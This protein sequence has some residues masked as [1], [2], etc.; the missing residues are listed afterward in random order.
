MNPTKIILFIAGFFVFI[1]ASKYFMVVKSLL[2]LRFKKT[3]GEIKQLNELPQYLK[4]LLPSYDIKLQ[5]LDFSLSHLHL[6]NTC[7]VSNFSQ[8][9]NLVYF[10]ENN[11]CYANATVSPLPE[12]H[13]PVKVEFNNIFSD[14]SRLVTQ[15][16]TECDIIGEVPN[17]IFCDPW[18]PTLEQQYMAHIEKLKSLNRESIKLSIQ[19]HLSSEIQSGNDYIAS[20][21][22]K[23]YLKSQD[24]TTWQLR[25]LPAMKHAFKTLRGIK[26]ITALK[27]AQMKAAGAKKIEPIEIPI[28]AEVNAYLHL[29]DLYKQTDSGLG[30]KLMVFFMSLALGIAIFGT[31]I[32]FEAAFFIIGALI[33]HELGHYIAMLIFGY[34]DRQILI[35]PFGAATLGK[36]TDA[37]ALQK[38]VVFLSGPALGLIAGTVCIIAGARNEI[39]PLVF[40]GGF[41]LLLN[42]LNLLPIV[43]LDGGRLFELALFSS[44]PVLKSVFL[45]MSVF[46][47][48]VAAILFK[49]PILIVFSVVMII[50]VRA[51]VLINSAHSK[52]KKQMKT[53]QIQS[54][55]ESILPE[56]FRL[57]KQKAFARLPFAKKYAISKNLVSELM[58]KPP[59]LAESIVSLA[60]YFLVFALP[61]L[62]AVP[63]LIFLGIKDRI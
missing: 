42:Y 24:E 37:S 26:K 59:E 63:T 57:L 27:A 19:D 55:K 54:D 52:I 34:S 40:C 6:L 2:N 10:N 49:D 16:G 1:K 35:L 4:T 17:A 43:P 7:V 50:G 46:V 36:K 20:L 25:L 39:K 41:F 14:K 62:I 51:Q 48:A 8:Q 56:I 12:T 28:E 22:Q 9:W 38:A 11:N 21:V 3:D 61:I 31:A 30:W 60:L 23:A 44:V 18:A 5:N 29:E 32:S 58:Q 47:V 45:I 53:Q 15:N 13:Q 33:V